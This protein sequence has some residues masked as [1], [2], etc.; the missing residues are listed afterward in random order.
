VHSLDCNPVVDKR[1]LDNL[2]GMKGCSCR[3]VCMQMPNRMVCNPTNS[4]SNKKVCNH[5]SMKV[6]NHS[7]K[8]VC[9]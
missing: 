2:I 1:A 6:C 7:N 8:K 4:H 3:M 5:S 9:S